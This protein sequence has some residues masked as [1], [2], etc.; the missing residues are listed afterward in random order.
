[1]MTEVWQKWE[2]QVVNGVFPLRRLLS[3]SDHSAVF[4]TESKAHD[5]V[6]AAIKLIRATPEQQAQL[7]CWTTAA[8]LSHP[9]LVQLLDSGRCEFE[10]LEFL[11]VVMEYAD[12]TLAQILPRR[13]LTADE[14]REMLVPTLNALS[15]L[16]SRNWVQGRLKPSNI[17]VVKD[18]IKLASDNARPGGTSTADVAGPSVYDPPEAKDGGYSAAGDMWSLG[19]TIVEALTQRPPSWPDSGF[20]TDAA[21]AA[22]PPSLA[23]IVRQCLDR[24]PANRPSAAQLEADINPAP[25]LPDIPVISPA[26][27]SASKRSASKRSVF[28]AAIAVLLILAVAVWAGRRML[29]SQ[30]APQQSDSIASAP[31]NSANSKSD[32]VSAQADQPAQAAQTVQP[33]SPFVLHEEIPDLSRGARDTIHG[34][35]KVDV[36]VTVDASGNVVE[37]SLGHG[38]TSRY[39]DRL[40]TAAAGKWKFTPAA[41][42]DSRKYLLRFEFSRSGATGR[43]VAPKS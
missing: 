4:L 7:A 41:D 38:G 13:A 31:E 19:I 35:I 29:G 1:M 8:S 25:A 11:Y 27:R 20:E 34:H 26:E 10:G 14:A 21:A 40:A 33:G 43:A 36:R 18:Q 32:S 9:H 42:Q 2:G 3:A 28:P 24:D 37:E 30:S 39:F 23:K 12:Q 16:H 22:V 17:L 15:F 5:I 6:D